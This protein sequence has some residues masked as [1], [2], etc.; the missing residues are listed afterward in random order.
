MHDFN[1]LR[2]RARLSSA[3]AAELLGVSQRTV[4]AWNRAERP[5]PRAVELVLQMITGDLSPFG[6]PGWL[7][8][9]G[10]LITPDGHA[11]R[12]GDV[13]AIYWREQLI[14][15]YRR[16]LRLLQHKCRFTLAANDAGPLRDLLNVID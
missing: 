1:D 4:R 8:A 12:P 2:V 7:L 11:Y 5:C 16:E 14:N 15:H 10:D 9:G 13:A 6:W 3:Q